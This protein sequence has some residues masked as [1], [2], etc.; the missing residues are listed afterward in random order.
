M[1]YNPHQKAEYFDYIKFNCTI[2]VFDEEVQKWIR[3]ANNFKKE[4]DK[5][6]HQLEIEP[7][8]RKEA[9]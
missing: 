6:L 9:I 8:S 1:F 2:Y 5:N 3:I 4:L 7:L